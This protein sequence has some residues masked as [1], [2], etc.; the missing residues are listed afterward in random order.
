M[1]ESLSSVVLNVIFDDI[2]Q[3]SFN[4]LFPHF[5]LNS[6]NPVVIID[7]L[8]K[9]HTLF[10]S[11]II[12]SGSLIIGLLLLRLF[13][14]IFLSVDLILFSKIDISLFSG[15]VVRLIKLSFKFIFSM[16]FTRSV[17]TSLLFFIV[18]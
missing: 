13:L 1:L 7:G 12:I 18:L 16:F 4:S 9:Y 5:R 10:L 17:R 6:F 15:K 8:L 3:L 14:L 11:E 2:L